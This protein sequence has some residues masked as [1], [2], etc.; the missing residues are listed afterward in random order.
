MLTSHY[1][2]KVGPRS[3]WADKLIEEL[4]RMVN[5]Q[6]ESPE[7]RLLAETPLTLERA[8]FYSAVIV[9]YGNNRRDCW[10]FV[11]AR[12]PYDVK[13][14][15]WQHEKDELIYDSRAGT[16]H[17]TLISREALALGMTQEELEAVQPTPLIRAALLSFTHL[18]SQ[19]HWLG[20]LTASHFL[21]R[22]NNPT[23]LS[24]GRNSTVRWRDRLINELGIDP[25][26]LSSSNVHAVAD[27][28]HSDLIEDVLLRHVANESAYEHAR[29]GAWEAQQI[30]RAYRAAV[31]HGM[32]A[33]GA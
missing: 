30:D 10:A 12:S 17:V 24:D 19:L 31:A 8:K 6:F 11:Q 18:A 3:K 13:Q 14:A 25:V 22:R 33:I 23:L 29:Q 26:R 21:E 15:I 27:E 9:I 4:N 16:D 5:E 1:G 20:A 28:E 32:R 2:A 7:F